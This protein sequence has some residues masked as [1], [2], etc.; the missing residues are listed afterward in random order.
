LVDIKKRNGE[1]IRKHTFRS[2]VHI[3]DEVVDTVVTTGR[4]PKT[5]IVHSYEDC[6]FDPV[7][8]KY[9]VDSDGECL[10]IVDYEVELILYE[11]SDWEI[12]LTDAKEPPLIV[13]DHIW[14]LVRFLDPSV[15]K[16]LHITHFY[17]D[18]DCCD[19]EVL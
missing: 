17:F 18:P 15:T 10:L 1:V 3:N 19:D 12:E 14:G 8:G 11:D 7:T 9:H 5:D 13:G 4:I 16:Y 2:Y 6:T